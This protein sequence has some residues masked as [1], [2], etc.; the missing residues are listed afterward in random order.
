[1]KSPTNGPRCSTSFT[2][3][4]LMHSH[5]LAHE[6]VDIRPPSLS[7]RDRRVP[8]HTYKDE[9]GARPL[10]G[11]QDGAKDQDGAEDGEELAGGRH[12]G[13]GEGTVHGDAEE[14][15]VL[16]L[17]SQFLMRSFG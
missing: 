11:P 8:H 3:N 12:H 16:E 2:L 10:P 6:I 4:T 15:E 5:H 9:D 17:E 14:D 13:G 1:M 7:R